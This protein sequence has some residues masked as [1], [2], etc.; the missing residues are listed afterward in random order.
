MK[1]FW[2]DSSLAL[3][4]KTAD[5]YSGARKILSPVTLTYKGDPFLAKYNLTI[6]DSGFTQSKMSMLKKNYYLEESI[7]AAKKLWKE[8]VARDKYGSVGFSCY[9]HY[10][11]GDVGGHT[12]RGSKFGPC[13]QAVTLTYNKRKTTVD[14]FYR[15]TELFKKFP[16]DLVFLRDVLLAEFDFKK[17]PIER[18]NFHF[19]NVTCHPMYW[20]T[21][22]PHL[23]DPI[24]EL[25]KIRR[26][27]KF[28]WQWIIKWSARY[29]CDEY[30]NGIQKFSQ[31]LRV[32]TMAK[33]L[34]G[35]STMKKLQAYF[36]KHHPKKL[37]DIEE[38]EDD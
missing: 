2:I 17:A 37:T 27:D 3:S 6:R 32:G 23:D 25:E 30:S 34:I 24:K 12:P 15:T 13:I 33:E 4:A 18:V 5:F 10:V 28:F 20:I 9:A 26:L 11:K 29:T 22:V 16:A 38:D 8:R 31:A 21:L 14:V 7:I 1:Q 35:K 19:A 36:R